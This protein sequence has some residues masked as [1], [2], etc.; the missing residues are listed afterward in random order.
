MSWAFTRASEQV[1]GA[2]GAHPS[3]P[4]PIL[5]LFLHAAVSSIVSWG[6]GVLGGP[7]AW[8]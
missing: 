5:V 2:A 8:A 6:G 3:P 7:F 1:W 4:S